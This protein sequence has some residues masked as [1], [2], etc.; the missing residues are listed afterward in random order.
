MLD[1]FILPPSLVKLNKFEL[2]LDNLY[3]FEEKYHSL[4]KFSFF[5]FTKFAFLHI[6]P[7]H[8]KLQCSNLVQFSNT[9]QG[10]SVS[11]LDN[12]PNYLVGNVILIL[13]NDFHQIQQTFSRKLARDILLHQLLDLQQFCLQYHFLNW[14]L[15]QIFFQQMLKLKALRV[16]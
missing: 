14:E 16:L 6:Y 8:P 4:D 9:I 11:L 13:T 3:H 12:G 15:D 2:I 10:L 7:E 5:F 1:T